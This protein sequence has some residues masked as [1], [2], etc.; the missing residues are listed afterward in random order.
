MIEAERLEAYDNSERL[1]IAT[2]VA[3]EEVTV[4]P[5]A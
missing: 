2:L 1:V 4:F 5:E 3:R